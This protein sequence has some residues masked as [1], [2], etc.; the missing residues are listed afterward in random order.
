VALVLRALQEIHDLARMTRE[1]A[2]G[3]ARNVEPIGALGA[4]A[5]PAGELDRHTQALAATAAA[6]H[7]KL[8]SVAPTVR[9]R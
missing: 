3:I 9:G 8:G 1:A 4:V 5:E 7:H 6:I 2:E